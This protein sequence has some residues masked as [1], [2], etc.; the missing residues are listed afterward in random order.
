MP[1]AA[2][3][4]QASSPVNALLILDELDVETTAFLL[5]SRRAVS[6]LDSLEIQ[7][8]KAELGLA[9]SID[10]TD[11]LSVDTL[12]FHFKLIQME[13]SDELEITSVQ[14][15]TEQYIEAV[16]E[17]A[18]PGD[19]V[20]RMDNLESDFVFSSVHP[21]YH[22]EF[23]YSEGNLTGYSIY[24][25]TSKLTKLFDVQLIS[26]NGL[27]TEKRV[28]R[29]SDNRILSVLFNYIGDVMVGQHRVVL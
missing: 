29:S 5:D 20:T 25:D 6:I 11:E 13:I 12:L 2:R 16:A 26:T 1:V 21:G 23:I 7:D 19:V 14:N 4:P 9:I 28:T 22:K 3:K 27:L 24:S 17:S 18:D 15:F 10:V 8:D